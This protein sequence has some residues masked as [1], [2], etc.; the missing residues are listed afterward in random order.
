M[1]P[2]PL[3]QELCHLEMRIAKQ[4]WDAHD[5]RQHLSIERT[6]AVANQ[7]VWLLTVNQ[8][9]DEL[10]GL[11]RMHGQVGRKHLYTTLEAFTQSQG[12]YALAT[13]IESMQE[14]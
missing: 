13:G 6:A 14:Q 8:S 4:S 10:N 9:A 12:W 3:F 11:L 2:Y 1:I 7:K 5:G